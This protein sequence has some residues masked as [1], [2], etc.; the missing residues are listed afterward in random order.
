MYNLILDMSWSLVMWVCAL[1]RLCLVRWCRVWCFAV[2][3][4]VFLYSCS[5][6]V[7]GGVGVCASVCAWCWVW[8]GWGGVGGGGGGGVGGGGGLSRLAVDH[9]GITLTALYIIS[10]K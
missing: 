10:G 9:N 6:W 8:G 3:L 2:L 7:C 4:Y 5:V 1:S